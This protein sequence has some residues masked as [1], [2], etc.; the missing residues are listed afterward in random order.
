MTYPLPPFTRAAEM[1]LMRRVLRA[2]VFAHAKRDLPNLWSAEH[3]E[4]IM[5]PEA[6]S[7]A[8]EDLSEELGPALLYAKSRLAPGDAPR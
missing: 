6:L 7:A 1:R 8:S 3:C 4:K 2:L 5:S